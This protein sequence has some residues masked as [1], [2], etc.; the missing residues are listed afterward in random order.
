LS[1]FIAVLTTCL[2]VAAS[3]ASASSVST[4]S[5]S[6]H[7]AHDTSFNP[8]ETALGV[9]NV[10]LLHVVWSVAHVS[11]AIATDSR[12]Y[13]IRPLRFAS[14]QVAVLYA[15]DGKNLFVYTPA[16]LRLQRGAF[17]TPMALAHPD[18]TLVVANTR[19]I[20][21]LNPHNG[22]LR[23]YAG[24]GATGIVVNWPVVYTG[25]GCQNPCGEL[26]SYALDLRTGKR[27]WT[28]RGNLAQTPVLM[29]GL[30]YQ[31]VGQRSAVTHVYSQS[32]GHL[33]GLLQINA[34]WLGDAH[35]AFAF[36]LVGRLP[37]SASV[38]RS[39][40]GE[41]GANGV[42]VWK[43]DLGKI[44]AGNPV[45]AYNTLFL[46]SNRHHPGVI[47]LNASNGRFLWGAD[48]GPSSS[49][50]AANHLLYVLNDTVGRVDI[51][52]TSNGA[53][54]RSLKV[55][56]FNNRGDTGLMI[57]GGTLYVLGGNGLVAFRP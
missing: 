32:S 15:A 39:W 50:V 19:E 16:M 18:D 7:D 12:V 54:L 48:V 57:A 5:M 40:V 52:R 44:L 49:M 9:G 45:L 26:A 28:H 33:A 2:L 20:V 56:G 14:S 10:R 46:P 29:K 42:A 35:R 53:V 3:N 21:A 37:G 31:T 24:G 6:G 23:W 8:D 47:A 55:P 27:I 34:R 41:I 51:M 43:A 22:R 17:D 4:W 36:V 38:G 13:V 25:K 11:S 30:L 1:R